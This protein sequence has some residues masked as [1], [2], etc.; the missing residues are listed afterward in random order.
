MKLVRISCLIGLLIGF[1]FLSPAYSQCT[2]LGQNPGTAFPVCGTTTFVQ[3]DVPI[4]SSNNLYV[5]G[6]Q[7]GANYA[8]KNPYWYK[9]HCYASG[10]LSFTITPKDLTDD[11]DWQLYDITGLNPDDVYTN[12]N[13]IVTGNWAG[14]PGET[15]A[16]ATGATFIQCASGY[17]GNEP[18]FARS[19][20][21]VAGHDYLLLVSHY[22]DSQ[23]G[24]DLSFAGG[25]AVITDPTVPH[26]AKIT[27]D[28]DG[29]TLTLKLNKKMRCNTLSIDA[30]DFVLSPAAATVQSVVAAN[31]GSAFDFDSIVITLSTR[32]PQGDYQ[33]VMKAGTDNNTLLDNC[34]QAIATGEQIAFRYGPPQ[35]ITADS[36]GTPKCAPDSIVIYYPKRIECSTISADGSDYSITGPSP[37]TVTRASG[38]CVN[39]RSNTVTVFFASPIVN[40]GLYTVTLK[41]GVDGGTITDEC[42]L[43]AL[44]HTRTFTAVD[45]V[46]AEF[47]Y[48]TLLDCRLNTLT[49]THDGAHDVNSWSWNFNNTVRV[50]TPVHTIKFPSTSTNTVSLVVSNG[51]CK[52]SVQST[53]TMNNE[54]IARY[55]MEPI[56]CPE[57]P[58]VVKN[59]SG[60][61]ID[62]WEWAF[63]N[64]AASSLKDPPPVQF[65]ITNIETNYRVRLIVTNNTL[66]CSDT[67]SKT[68]KVLNNC[69]IAVPS[70]FTPNNDGRNDFLY[71]N[72]AIKAE[73]LDFRVYNRWGQI[74]FQSKDWTQ[75]WNGKVDGIEQASGV[76]VWMLRYKH[77]DTGKEVF[78]KGTVTLIR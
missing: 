29:K 76:Y 35:P 18:R 44:P 71:P 53:I 65:P 11:Y 9:F 13:I 47:T 75:K 10:S 6:C 49:F 36:I 50:N 14:N 56:I 63:G 48:A 5:P 23:S 43:Q 57:D 28:C 26:M 66:G 3:D 60:G 59:N 22:T 17:T 61:L 41:P 15:G 55:D 33:L 67:L 37:V 46:S 2:T 39:G 25:T 8:N 4:C 45:T 40:K 68:V 1:L 78:Q 58:L 27:P 24:Y 20:N 31:C 32:L 54:V 51:I 38:N 70:A 12:R 77:R 19:P 74:V 69:F 73:N 30:S 42:G 52:D 7:D 72:N 34:G 64:I 16:S 62:N 21:L